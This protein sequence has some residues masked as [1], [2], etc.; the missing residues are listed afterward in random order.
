MMSNPSAKTRFLQNAVI[1]TKHNEMVSDPAFQIGADIGLLEYQE[2]LQFS[3]AGDFNKCA[4]NFMKLQGA[5]E[6]LFILRNLG[7]REKAAAPQADH[8]NLVPRN[9]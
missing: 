1:V 8:I 3:T 6:F 7:E 4:A 9:S 5:R 2:Q